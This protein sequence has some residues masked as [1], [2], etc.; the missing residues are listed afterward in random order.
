M[1][2]KTWEERAESG[3]LL[4][5]N[6]NI[7]NAIEKILDDPTDEN[8]D[9]FAFTLLDRMLEFGQFIVPIE[10]LPDDP[11]SFLFK[12]ISG[13]DESEIFLA[14]F[15]DEE[16][17]ERGP[18]S[19][20]LLYFIDALFEHALEYED[21]AGVVINPWGDAFELPRD[22]IEKALEAKRER[23]EEFDPGKRLDN[24]IVYA[25]AVH[26]GQ[27]R[28]G[29][30][31]PYITH[32]LEVMSILNHMKADPNLMIAGLLHD[33][34][35]DTETTIEDI[36]ERF[37]DDVANLVG[38]HSEN[39]E[40]SWEE[41]KTQA[42][43]HARNADIRT[44]LLILA[45][46]VS[47]LRTMYADYK[48]VGEDL[49]TRFNAGK[50]MQSWYYSEIQDA[51]SEMQNYIETESIYWEMV[52]LYKDIFV[53]FRF[54]E[55][56]MAIYQFNSDTI[57]RLTKDYPEWVE[58]DEETEGRIPERAVEIGR[59]RAEGIEDGWRDEFM[60]AATKLN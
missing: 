53:K 58:Y 32:P 25:T 4:I 19:E 45:D 7:K 52:E 29:T 59:K 22:M 36:V 21:A 14:A 35:E 56:A 46:K 28:K 44:K 50:D 11:E 6:V 33:T 49:W 27:N 26:S 54:D 42:I 2:N 1:D 40:L 55:K 31:R 34:V 41:R 48:C 57:F 23:L 37:G 43:E 38:S 20:K 47:N 51:L 30:D 24:A 18:E 60:A 13:E 5:G 8:A 16:E 10:S 15:T 12:T 9:K 17:F 39:K 3:E